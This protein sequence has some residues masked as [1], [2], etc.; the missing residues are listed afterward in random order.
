MTFAV[1]HLR[2]LIE[3]TVSEALDQ[4]RPALMETSQPAKVEKRLLTKSEAAEYLGVEST[5]TVD[6]IAE[7]HGIHIFKDKGVVRFDRHDLDALIERVKA[8]DAALDTPGLAG[9]D[10]QTAV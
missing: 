7:D 1:E 6:R 8:G 10:P 5:R 9:E 3:A 2:P 4:L